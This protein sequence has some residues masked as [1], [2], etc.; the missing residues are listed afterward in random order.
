MKLGKRAPRRDLRTLKLSDYLTPELPKPPIRAGYIDQVKS[1]PM[2]LNDSLGDCA[3]AC[4]GHQIQQWTTYAGTPFVPRDKDILKAYEDVGGYKPGDPSTD[5]GCYILD[6]L[7]YWRKTGI[8]GHKIL[9][10]ASVNFNN[11]TE[12][13]QAIYLFGSLNVGVAL[14][15]S[16]QNPTHHD[17]LGFCKPCWSVPKG[18]P[19]GD[20]SPGSWGGHC[21]PIVGYSNDPAGYPGV[22]VITWG[23]VYD[24]TWPFIKN[25]MDEAWV[26]LTQDWINAAGKTPTGLNLAQLQADLAA[27]R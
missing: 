10:F 17:P 6:V 19:Y 18:G 22:E 23:A 2:L 13:E 9:A 16:A 15:L 11:R 12:M 25:Y 20:G 27:I 14:P 26:I 7:K 1:W 5:N 8:A 4:P 3:V 24:M 21:I